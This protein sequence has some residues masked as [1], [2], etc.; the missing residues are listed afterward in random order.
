MT[1][2][3]TLVDYITG[4]EPDIVVKVFLKVP[5]HLAILGE[6]GQIP[7]FLQGF[8]AMFKILA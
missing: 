3:S 5:Q 4:T 8:V 6:S 2:K 1:N 7:F